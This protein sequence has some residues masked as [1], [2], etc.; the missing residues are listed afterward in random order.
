MIRFF[1]KTNIVVVY[2]LFLALVLIPN[3]LVLFFPNIFENPVI[4]M[5]EDVSEGA[6]FVMSVIVAPI[7]ETLIFQTA[8]IFII[9]FAI[10]N[11]LK[12]FWLSLIVSSLLFALNHIYSIAY[13][14]FGIYVGGLFVIAY[15]VAQ[16]RKVSATLFVIAIHMMNNLIAFFV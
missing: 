7:F 6:L 9:Q 16:K 1:Q 13:F 12:R 10:Q 14:F 15:Y 8:I 4:S 2:L 5:F 11:K 3:F